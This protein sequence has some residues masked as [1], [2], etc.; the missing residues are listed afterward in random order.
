MIGRLPDS[1]TVNGREYPIRTDYRDILTIMEAYEDPDL[2]GAEKAFTMLYIL[3]PD[4]EE[5]PQDDLEEA[6]RQAAWFIDC[7]AQMKDEA[8]RTP[9]LVDWGQDERLLFPAVNTAAGME[10]RAV[11]YMHWWTFMGYFMEIREGTYAQV[12]SLRQK[13]AKGKKLEK[14]ELEYW[15]NN[16]DICQLRK[17]LSSEEI[18]E[19]ER[20]KALLGG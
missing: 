16:R 6:F 5:I 19:Q 12:L 8:K 14:W 7:G 1:L 11:E 2:D 20:L 10:V 3:Y 4:F 17:R 9:R 13:K 18:E 15:Q